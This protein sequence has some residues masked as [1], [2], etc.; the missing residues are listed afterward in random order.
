MSLDTN[1]RVAW[2]FADTATVTPISG[3]GMTGATVSVPAM[4][5]P[6]SGIDR[7][8]RYAQTQQYREG[9]EHGDD[10]G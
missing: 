7:E 1:F 5:V 9:P 4:P 10:P 8:Q 6:G 3:Q 2:A